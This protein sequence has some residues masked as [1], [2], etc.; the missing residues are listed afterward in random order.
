MQI[1]QKVHLPMKLGDQEGIW[2]TQLYTDSLSPKIKPRIISCT[3][4]TNKL[5]PITDAYQWHAHDTI[6]NRLYVL[7]ELF[8]SFL[9]TDY[10]WGRQ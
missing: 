5:V 1:K 2:K 6:R 7:F 10:G 8:I 4:P 3:F 9:I